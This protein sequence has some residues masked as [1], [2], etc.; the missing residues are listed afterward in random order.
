MTVNLYT[1]NILGR[2]TFRFWG[3]L[4]LNVGVVYGGKR[5][6]DTI[7]FEKYPS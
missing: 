2:T 7:Y 3:V 6:I 5:F 1:L 4:F